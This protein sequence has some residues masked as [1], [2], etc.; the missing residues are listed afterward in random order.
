MATIKEKIDA[1][2]KEAMLARNNTKKEV[3]KVVKSEIS[4]EEAG[5]KVYGDVEVIQLIRKTI[6][7]LETIGTDQSREEIVILD[8]F[9]PSKMSEEKI[10]EAVSELITE[11]G[12]AGNKSM[13]GKVMQAFNAKYAGQADGKIVSKIVSESL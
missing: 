12:A 13:M 10:K 2:I 7:N 1:G 11:F 6:K 5:I 3:L 8:T 4:R 9:V